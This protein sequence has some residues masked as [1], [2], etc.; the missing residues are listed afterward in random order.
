MITSWIHGPSGLPLRMK[1]ANGFDGR[2]VIASDM[3]VCVDLWMKPGTRAPEEMMRAGAQVDIRPLCQKID[4]G[5]ILVVGAASNG[6][7]RSA[8]NKRIV[9]QRRKILRS[10][11]HCRDRIMP[12]RVETTH[13]TVHIESCLADPAKRVSDLPALGFVAR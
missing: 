9:A 13:I 10:V 8:S 12:R 1:C 3:F 4:D 6:R 5:L 2:S 7:N 11:T